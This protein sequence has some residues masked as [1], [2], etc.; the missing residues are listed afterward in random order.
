MCTPFVAL[1]APP[2]AC[3]DGNIFNGDGCSYQCTVEPGFLC[4]GGEDLVSA[5]SCFLGQLLFFD[6]FEQ[7]TASGWN[8]LT[9]LKGSFSVGPVFKQGGQYG[10]RLVND[11]RMLEGVMLFLYAVLCSVRFALFCTLYSVLCALLCSVRFAL[12]CVLCCAVLCCAVR[13]VVLCCTLY[14]FAQFGGPSL[15]FFPA[16]PPPPGWNCF[17]HGLTLLMHATFPLATLCTRLSG[18]G[19]ER[20]IEERHRPWRHRAHYRCLHCALDHHPC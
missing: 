13:C 18:A 7:G 20:R 12:L 9:G 16:P 17:D 2:Q 8:T 15:F 5:D 14:G 10:S 11:A 4:I 19:A 6:G 3:D 1:L